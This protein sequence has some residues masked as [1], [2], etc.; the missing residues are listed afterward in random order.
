MWRSRS[1]GTPR[2]NSA[3]LRGAILPSPEVA[4]PPTLYVS[5]CF[6][7]FVVVCPCTI[8]RHVQLE[9]ANACRRN[10]QSPSITISSSPC[11][12]LLV[13]AS[14]NNIM[15]PRSIFTQG[16][17]QVN[18]SHDS[19]GNAPCEG[20]ATYVHEIVVLRGSLR[21]RSRIQLCC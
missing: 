9:I 15:P 8:H 12:S 11:R 6:D 17:F 2:T 7:D 13:A 18:V 5:R 19:G 1:Q 4:Y 14:N 20:T 21:N 16:A 10:F 3:S